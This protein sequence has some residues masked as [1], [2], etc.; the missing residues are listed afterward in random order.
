MRRE[1]FLF[2]YFF[3]FVK[4]LFFFWKFRK[5]FE[6]SSLF[7]CGFFQVWGLRLKPTIHNMREITL[8]F[9]GWRQEKEDFPESESFIVTFPWNIFS[10]DR[11][12]AQISPFLYS[13]SGSKLTSHS[14][15]ENPKIVL[16]R[17]L[18]RGDTHN[19]FYFTNSSVLSFFVCFGSFIVL[20]HQT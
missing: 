20:W 17:Q 12:S 5:T 13:F 18:L 10:E 8:Q 16:S 3:L 1:R 4:F 14:K 11:S 6:F 19:F 15:M 7:F 9:T 2:V